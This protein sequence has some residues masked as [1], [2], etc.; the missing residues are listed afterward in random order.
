MFIKGRAEII[1]DDGRT[2]KSKGKSHFDDEVALRQLAGDGSIEFTHLI[3]KKLHFKGL[4]KGNTLN[5]EEFSLQGG[6][7]VSNLEADSVKISFSSNSKIKNVISDSVMIAPEKGQNTTVVKEIF[8][9]LFHTEFEIPDKTTA[10]FCVENITANKVAIE[11]CIINTICCKNAVV[12]SG[13][14]ISK[15][16]YSDYCEIMEG[17]VVSEKIKSFS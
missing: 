4:L 16:V 10:S 1:S 5:C 12:G 6:V 11:G 15:L 9:K 7:V 14:K 3:A 8:E 13:C 2:V 17:A